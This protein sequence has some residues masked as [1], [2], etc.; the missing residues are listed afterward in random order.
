MTSIQANKGK[1]IATKIRSK[2]FRSIP[3][4]NGFRYYAFLPWQFLYFF[5]L[6]QG[7]GS[8]RPT[9]SPEKIC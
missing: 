5:P 3:N 8:F 4:S 7:H 6:P 2:N 1:A 9:F